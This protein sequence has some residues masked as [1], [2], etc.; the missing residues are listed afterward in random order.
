M[1][2]SKPIILV[3]DEELVLR[4]NEQWLQLAGF[5]TECF[6]DPRL[7]LQRLQSPFE[8]VLVSD[9]KMPHMDGLELMER[10]LALC[11]ELPI[12]LITAHGDV[13]MAVR[14]V[15]AGAYDF[16]EKPFDPQRLVKT[17][18]RALDQLRLRSQNRQLRERLREQSGIGAK[19]LGV[20]PAMRQLHQEILEVSALNTHVVIYGETGSGKELVAQS[21]HEYGQHPNAPFVALNC[22]AIPEPLFESELFGHEAGA[23]SGAARRRI[24]KFEFANGGTLF[25]DEIESMPSNLQT[26]VLR[27]IQEQRIERL[28]SN[29][30]IELNNRILSAS[31][32]NLQEQEDFRQDLYYR[33]NISEIHIPPLRERGEDIPLLFNHFCE[34]AASDNNL[35]QRTLDENDQV[36]LMSHH[37]PGNV[38]ELRNIATRFALGKRSLHELLAQKPSTF[39][40]PQPASYQQSLAQ[41]VNQYECSLIQQSLRKHQGNI[42]E[43]MRELDLPRRTLNQKMQKYA[44]NRTDYLPSNEE[45]A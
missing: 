37:W 14:S 6:T 30:T 25:F 19:L 21:I 33:L 13:D 16:I 32:V 15:Q 22:A 9:I 44:L 10:A 45:S 7:A 18:E 38:R 8:G 35:P 12:V 1:H 11:P 31:K 20:S 5:E 39:D 42:T 23:F 36:L 4:A 27:A 43:V 17:L 26:K 3:D 24:G 2:P 41:K 34:L 29:Q 40:P 28:G